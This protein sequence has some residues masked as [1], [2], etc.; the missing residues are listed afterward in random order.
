MPYEMQTDLFMGLLQ[1]LH[2]HSHHHIDQHKLCHQDKHHEEKWSH[3]LV[4]TAVP[5]TFFGLIALLSKCVLH[6]SI[7]IVTC[8]LVFKWNYGHQKAELT[9]SNPEQCEEGHPKRP[10]VGMFP[11]T[12]TGV[13]IITF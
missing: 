9:C 11:Q 3:I 6:D 8:I 2:E 5:E 12:L 4:N 1:V 13:L 10:E 7:P